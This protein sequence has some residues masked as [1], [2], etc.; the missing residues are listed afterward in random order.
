MLR[1][2]APPLHSLPCFASSEV[3]VVCLC[4]LAALERSAKKHVTEA[5][6]CARCAVGS[7][8]FFRLLRR[9]R[10]GFCKKCSKVASSSQLLKRERAAASTDAYHIIWLPT[11]QQLRVDIHRFWQIVAVRLAKTTARVSL[12]L[13]SR[14]SPRTMSTNGHRESTT[15]DR[16]SVPPD[17][18]AAAAPSTTGTNSR[19]RT[20]GPIG[21]AAAVCL[22]AALPVASAFAPM[23]TELT[24]A[25]GVSAGSMT[26][27]IISAQRRI[28]AHVV[29]TLSSS[30]TTRLYS[31]WSD[32][33]YIDDDDDLLD[34]DSMKSIDFAD[35]NDPQELKAQVGSSLEPPELDWFG[36]PI[37]VPLGVALPLEP[38]TIQGL[39]AACR[40]E[41]GTMFGYSAEN[42][43]VGITGGV[44]F[45]E[46]DGPVVVLRLK[47]RFWHQ[48]TTVL[49]R[50]AAYLQGRCPEIVDVV[51]ED[52]WQLTD[53]ANNAA[54]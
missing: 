35:E 39:L 34:S 8:P 37:E 29:P 19:R 5:K 23:S 18:D 44:D 49:D 32:F 1:R 41:I 27:G 10:H 42:R 15:A 31:D 25:S 6:R 4:S 33:S 16:M 17:D 13:A 52:E 22:L 24:A 53:E 46:L 45:V 51:V 43:G 11:L 40:E 9:T 48:R 14:V 3:C 21:A 36:D 12:F 54:V 28:P 50:V 47:G 38:D 26:N 20:K 30:T 2:Y 7:N